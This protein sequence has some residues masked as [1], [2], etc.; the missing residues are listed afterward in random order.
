M[1]DLAKAAVARTKP[2][3]RDQSETK[4]GCSSGSEPYYAPLTLREE[5][6]Y[7]YTY[8][9]LTVCHEVFSRTLMGFERRHGSLH[10]LLHHHTS[11]IPFSYKTKLFYLL[12][13]VGNSLTPYSGL[14]ILRAVDIA[15]SSSFAPAGLAGLMKI[16]L[17]IG[18]PHLPNSQKV[19][20]KCSESVEIRRSLE[21]RYCILLDGILTFL[22]PTAV[23]GCCNTRAVG[24]ME[25]R[26]TNL[27]GYVTKRI[28][29]FTISLKGT[30]GE[31]TAFLLECISDIDRF[32]WHTALA[33][34]I[35]HMDSK[36][37]SKWLY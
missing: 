10:S 12:I 35:E 13:I 32:K 25:N 6:T 7:M 19:E 22:P 2:K 37:G 24:S 18:S 34:H 5:S 36:A 11:P 17:S 4:D 14:N 3:L 21:Q 30:K 31:G 26:S 27:S 20:I 29:D 15:P 9:P 8:M 33:A 1:F 28:N 16:T 23:S